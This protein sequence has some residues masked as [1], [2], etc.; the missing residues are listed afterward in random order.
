MYAYVARISDH[1]PRRRASCSELR[2]RNL[3]SGSLFFEIYLRR[4][5]AGVGFCGECIRLSEQPSSWPSSGDLRLAQSLCE[6]STRRKGG[7]S[8]NVCRLGS[9]SESVLCVRR[10]T[11]PMAATLRS[12]WTNW[13]ICGITKL[14]TICDHS[15]CTKISAWWSTGDDRYITLIWSHLQLRSYGVMPFALI[16]SRYNRKYAK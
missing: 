6:R 4:A 16:A 10:R 9:F 1:I 12:F 7:G 5:G 13:E 15:V 11:R 3:V 2:V 8:Y 14:D